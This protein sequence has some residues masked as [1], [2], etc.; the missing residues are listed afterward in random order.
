MIE[1]RKRRR[2]ERR[3]SEYIVRS[4]KKEKK[5]KA[6]DTF[7]IVKCTYFFD[8]YSSRALLN[9]SSEDNERD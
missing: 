5:K 8:L 7:L 4:Y 2:T 3:I 1:R 9:L 6:H